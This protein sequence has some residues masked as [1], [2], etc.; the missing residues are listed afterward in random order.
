MEDR[1]AG[2]ADPEEEAAD[3]PAPTPPPGSLDGSNAPPPS[4]GDR[5]P[6]WRSPQIPAKDP[7][8]PAAAAGK[9]QQ[10]AADTEA[11]APDH[12]S[13][14]PVCSVRSSDETEASAAPEPSSADRR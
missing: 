3:H 6:A 7:A 2:V 5:P 11:P 13:A 8:E 4:P 9:A 12:H 14:N 1:P 10:A